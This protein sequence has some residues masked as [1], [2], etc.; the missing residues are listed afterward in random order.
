MNKIGNF[1]AM[2]FLTFLIKSFTAPL[3]II[4]IS[5]Y[6][7]SAVLWLMLLSRINLS[8]AYPALSLSYIVVLL[9][10]WFYLK[11]T[12]SIYQFIGVALIIVG[13]YLIVKKI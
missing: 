8:V 4:G 2:P 6:V 12:V 13:V 11:E 9:I 5:L 10:S 7:V 3:V 1:S